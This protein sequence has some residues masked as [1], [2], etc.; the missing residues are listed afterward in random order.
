MP[1]TATGAPDT[2]KAFEAL[3]AVSSLQEQLMYGFFVS[4]V[5]GRLLLYVVALFDL[6]TSFCML[7]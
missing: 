4:F 6:C 3:A 5:I 1:V 7:A 2:R